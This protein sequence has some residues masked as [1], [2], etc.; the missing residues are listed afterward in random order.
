MHGELNFVHRLEF[1]IWILL[2]GSID[3]THNPNQNLSEYFVEINK[4]ILN[5][6]WKCRGPDVARTISKNKKKVGGFM[7]LDFKTYGIIV[8]NTVCGIGIKLYADSNT[9]I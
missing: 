7:L 2:S 4:L 5:F 3:T 1:K 8:T 6:R 9:Y